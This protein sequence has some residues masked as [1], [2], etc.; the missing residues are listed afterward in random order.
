MALQTA[1]SPGAAT[2]SAGATVGGTSE[3][4]REG[5]D[6]GKPFAGGGAEGLAKNVLFEVKVGTKMVELALVVAKVV[7]RISNTW[8]VVVLVGGLAVPAC[9][10]ITFVVSGI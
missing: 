3:P 4:T 10:G 9:G 8:F 1:S 5:D 2:A 7:V 6:D